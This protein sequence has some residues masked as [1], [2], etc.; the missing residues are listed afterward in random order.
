MKAVLADIREQSETVINMA[1][2]VENKTKKKVFYF[3]KIEGDH[4]VH[5]TLIV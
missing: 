5:K 1:Q 3:R 4:N 2:R